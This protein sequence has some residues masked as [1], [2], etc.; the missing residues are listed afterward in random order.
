MRSFSFTLFFLLTTSFGY[1]QIKEFDKMEMLYAQGHYKLVLFK[2]NQL[3]DKPDFD[4]SQV[5]KFYKSLSLFQLAQNERWLKRHPEALN[6]AKGLFEKIKSAEDGYAV[7]DAHMIEVSEL[8]EDLFQWGAELET[9]GETGL[10]KQLETILQEMF[11]YIPNIKEENKKAP[12]KTPTAPSGDR[13]KL[14]AHAQK[15]L[16]VPYKWAGV[17]PD[18]FDC[19][20][21][22]TYIFANANIQLPRRAAD[23]FKSAKEVKEKSVQKGDLVF[24][25]NGGGV[26]H[27]GIIVSE[28]GEPLSMIHASSSSGIVITNIE[29]SSYWKKR[30]VGFGS[31]F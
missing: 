6:E 13:E 10:S 16:G 30:V 7:L 27:V 24:F 9:R 20:G 1:G 22:T 5:P 2:A 12:I 14:I 15:Y 17:T 28:P 26:S 8:K 25:A 18:G 21:Y 4:Y 3:L 11:N 23:Q 19:S 31:Y 29:T